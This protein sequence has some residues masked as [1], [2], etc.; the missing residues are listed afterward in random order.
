MLPLSKA[1][2]AALAAA[3][4]TTALLDPCEGRLGNLPEKLDGKE[5]C[6]PSD[7]N[8]GED[9]WGRCGRNQKLD[10]SYRRFLPSVI[11]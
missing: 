8:V 9:V 1:A 4:T 7:E 3:T 10:P 6:Q 5:L 11:N 2:A